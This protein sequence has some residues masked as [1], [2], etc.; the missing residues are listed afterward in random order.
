MYMGCWRCSLE[1][2]LGGVGY[3]VA[4]QFLSACLS[5]SGKLANALLSRGPILWHKPGPFL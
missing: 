5:E 1:E 3:G 4:L 2:Q